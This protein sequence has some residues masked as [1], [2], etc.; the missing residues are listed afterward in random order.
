M[1]ASY[2]LRLAILSVAVLF[3]AHLFF[4]IAVAMGVPAVVRRAER[5]RA[6]TAARVLF[7]LRIMPAAG[8]MFVVC[9]ICIPSYLRLEPDAIQEDVGAL[10]LGAAALGI[11]VWAFSIS[12]AARALI[13]SMRYVRAWRNRAGVTAIA[14]ARVWLIDGAG[15]TLALAGVFRPKLV[16]S[17]DVVDTLPPDQLAA[18]VR[19]ELA[20]ANAWD[21]FKRLLILLTPSM[22]L[23][24]RVE[25]AWARF[26]E[27][28]ADDRAAEGDPDRSLSLAAALVS[29][30][31]MGSPAVPPLATALMANAADLQVRV[32]R[33]L[34]ERSEVQPVSP[35]LIGGSLLSGAALVTLA[36]H[37][38]TLS[39]AYQMLERLVD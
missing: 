20:H 17:R 24:G 33:L 15:P 19:H 37:P 5:W 4:G 14:D 23:P 36:L 29:V 39:V 16:V 31:R 3:L 9:A 1:T 12:R 2:A 8:A 11:A 28:S 35:A 25:A 13:R 10:C 26:T 32:D 27:W 34:R 38:A 30:A 7:A 18:A 6:A 21:N 22:A